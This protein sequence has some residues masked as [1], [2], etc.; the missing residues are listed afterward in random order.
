MIF[1]FQ[2]E[3][4]IPFTVN[5][6]EIEQFE[7]IFPFQQFEKTGANKTHINKAFLKQPNVQIQYPGFEV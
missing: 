6:E 3:F 1:T 4:E 2:P 7:V 5:F